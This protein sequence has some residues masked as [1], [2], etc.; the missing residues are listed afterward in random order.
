M[1]LLKAKKKAGCRN[2]ERHY[3]VS[4]HTRQTKSGINVSVAVFHVKRTRSPFLQ[5]VGSLGNISG[6]YVR[7]SHYMRGN[8][9]H[10]MRSDW[11]RVGDQLRE[12]MAA[13]R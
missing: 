10:D 8:Y 2:V 7:F 1:T 3:L 9:I 6:G 4:T 12:S 5:G 13:I 11:Q